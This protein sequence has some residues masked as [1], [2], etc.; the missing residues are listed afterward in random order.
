MGRKT[1]PSFHMQGRDCS[2]ERFL[3]D[4]RPQ[5]IADNRN[6]QYHHLQALL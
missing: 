5:I 3:E 2:F 4:R 6:N 1:A